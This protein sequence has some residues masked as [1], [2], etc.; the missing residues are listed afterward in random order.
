MRLPTPRL[1]ARNLGY[2]YVDG[3]VAL[4]SVDLV[5]EPGEWLALVG[6]NGSGKTTLA[7]LLA[8]L[9]RPTRGAVLL[10]SRPMAALS[11]TQVSHAVAMAQQDPD[12]QIFASTTAA[13][14]AFGPSNLGLAP[15]VVRKRTES[16]LQRLGLAEFSGAPP[17]SL[18]YGL[19]RRVTIA[20][21]L[22][23]EPGIMILDEPTMGLEPRSAHELM[24]LLAELNRA[25]HTLIMVSHDMELVAEYARLCGVLQGGRM[26]A[27]GLTGDVLADE[28]LL[29]TTRLHAPPLVQLQSELRRSGVHIP[30]QTVRD[31]SFNLQAH[32]QQLAP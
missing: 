12:N 16:A 14:V 26:L 20:S 4:D 2:R 6:Q 11:I 23:L 17:A 9:L 21:L 3:Q 18:S 28:A 29:Q 27:L 1:Q 30:G 13:E 10:D 15:Q 8:G 5:V 25:G 31:F 7:L 32:R 19:R 22:A 24:R